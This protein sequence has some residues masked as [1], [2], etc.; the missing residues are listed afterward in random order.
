MLART[1]QHGLRELSV[2]TQPRLRYPFPRLII[3]ITAAGGAFGGML[4][5]AGVG[6]AIREIASSVN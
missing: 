6:E 4:Q 2:E 1:K 5:E 3:L